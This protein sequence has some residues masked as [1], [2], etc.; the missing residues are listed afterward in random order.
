MQVDIHKNSMDAKFVYPEKTKKLVDCVAGLYQSQQDILTA[1]LSFG[2]FNK[3]ELVRAFTEDGM[4]GIEEYITRS[5]RENIAE[6]FEE[7]PETLKEE[8]ESLDGFNKVNRKDGAEVVLLVW[9]PEMDFKSRYQLEVLRRTLE[10]H[11]VRTIMESAL[12]VPTNE[13]FWK[14]SDIFPR[15]AIISG[16]NTLYPSGMLDTADGAARKNLF[17]QQARV[18]ASL[19][20]ARVISRSQIHEPTVFYVDGG[21]VVFDNA[22][23]RVFVENSEGDFGVLQAIRQDFNRVMQKDIILLPGDPDNP[24]AYH[25][26]LFIAVLPHGEI[27]YNPHHLNEKQRQEIP[28]ILDS[29][30]PKPTVIEITAKEKDTYATNLITFG[31]NKVLLTMN[32]PVF[33]AKLKELGYQPITPK[34]VGFDKNWNIS[35]AGVRCLTLGPFEVKCHKDLGAAMTTSA[36]QISSASPS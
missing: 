36:Q 29:L 6:L 32:A 15:D 17:A 13:K 14:E 23:N 30:S 3:D 8:F 4:G 31:G 34:S 33:E 22:N 12:F 2:V 7:F 27:V 1:V 11:G 24:K 21:N 25:L 26:D 10:L 16:G 9:D 5:V 28:K 19:I 20:E 18:M 35:N